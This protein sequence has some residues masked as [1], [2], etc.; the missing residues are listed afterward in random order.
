MQ[1]QLYAFIV[2]WHAYDCQSGERDKDMTI[3]HTY[4]RLAK[5]ITDAFELNP[6]KPE[7]T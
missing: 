6:R 7:R 4:D 2:K 3:Y 5:A 1:E